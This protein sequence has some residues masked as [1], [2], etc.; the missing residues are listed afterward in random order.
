MIEAR[1]EFCKY[2]YPKSGHKDGDYAIA[3]V[4][5]LQNISGEVKTNEFWKNATIKGRMPKLQKGVVYKLKADEKYNEQYKNY[6]YEVKYIGVPCKLDDKDDREKFLKTILT[7]QQFKNLTESFENP[8]QIILNEDVEQLCKVKGIK[9]KTAN[10]I[11]AKVISNMDYSSAFV[12]LDNYDIT[13]EMIKKLVDIYGS[14]EVVVSKIKENPYIL[15]T[16]IDGI[17]FKRADEIALQ[18]GLSNNSIHRFESFIIYFLSEQAISGRSYVPQREVMG[19]IVDTLKI[20]YSD[21][22]TMFNLKQ[23]IYSLEAKRKLWWDEKKTVL[24]LVKYRE[25]E[26]EIAREIKRLLDGK[27]TFKYDNWLDIVNSIE[28]EQGWKYTKEQKD[29]VKTVLDNNVV[30]VTG[31]AGTGKTTVT[32]AMTRILDDCLISQCAL[33]GRAS[34]RIAENTGMEAHTIHR[35]LKYTKQGFGYN[36]DFPLESDIVIFDEASMP[37]LELV[38]ALLRA[39]KTGSKVI[40]IGDYGQ[41]SA[42][43]AGNFFMDLLESG[44]VPVVRLTEVHRQAQASAITSKSIEIRQQKQLFDCYFE[45]DIVLGEL[46]DLELSIRKM[47]EELPELILDKFDRDYKLIGNDINKVQIIVPTRHRGELC[48]AKLNDKI[49]KKYNP[50]IREEGILVKGKK[51]YE[52]SLFEGDRIIVTKNNKKVFRPDGEQITIFNGNLG[53]V[54]EVDIE[55]YRIIIDINGVGEVVIEGK[56]TMQTIELAYAITCHKLQGSSAEIVIVGVD[57]SSY[58]L[59]S[60]EWLY[61]AITRGEKFVTLVGE[62]K[63]IRTAINKVETKEKATFLPFA[64]KGEQF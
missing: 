38:L 29:G 23:A 60:C 39:I 58:M 61:T 64:L 44:V 37:N 51:G 20:D 22:E 25:M 1:V 10:D 13:N 15:A 53:I 27:N 4:Y 54:K 42:I 48:C 9:E 55:H 21:E 24:A 49:Q 32:K 63:A 45:G 62:N 8:L 33:S 52:Y 28:E 17:G 34:Q 57:Y 12:E 31:L 50:N 16:E 26:Y 5:V 6:E 14:P 36:K 2:M 7:E 19:A 43:G 41:L 46:K 59:L 18:G 11:I 40:I 30:V 35:L 56:K 3:S 47:R